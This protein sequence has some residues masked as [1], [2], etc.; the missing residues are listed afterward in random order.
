MDDHGF[1]RGLLGQVVGWVLFEDE[2]ISGAPL[3]KTSKTDVFVRPLSESLVR[4]ILMMRM[5]FAGQLNWA[6]VSI[7]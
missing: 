1:E 2:E 7:S 6:I 3:F 4:L 5:R